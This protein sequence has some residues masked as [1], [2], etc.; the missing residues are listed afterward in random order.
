MEEAKLW[1]DLP[2]TLD[3]QPELV[4]AM[5][6][7]VHDDLYD[8]RLT[9]AQ[10]NDCARAA[11]CILAAAPELLAMCKEIDCELGEPADWKDIGIELHL[12]LRALIAKAKGE[13]E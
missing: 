3:V 1:W 10:W 12:R 6:S 11:K 13:N 2:W 4:N 9:E 8:V 5:E 7:I